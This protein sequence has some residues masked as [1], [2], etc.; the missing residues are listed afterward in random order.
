MGAAMITACSIDGR[1]SPLLEE[2]V[3]AASPLSMVLKTTR[4]G[5]RFA[6]LTPASTLSP[7]AAARSAARIGTAPSERLL[8]FFY[9]LRYALAQLQRQ[10]DIHKPP[11]KATHTQLACTRY[12]SN[13]NSSGT[14]APASTCGS[15]ASA[16]PLHSLLRIAHVEKFDLLK[17]SIRP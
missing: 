15:S 11:P 12:S 7:H 3:S 17:I 14:A 13:L 6:G 4:F 8:V 10:M 9:N 5:E 16:S 2:L 1:L